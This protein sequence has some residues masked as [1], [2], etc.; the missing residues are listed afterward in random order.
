MPRKHRITQ[1]DVARCLG[2]DRTTVTKI[3]NRDSGYSASPETRERVYEVAR[4]LGYDF[5]AIRR[6]YRREYGRA[7]VSA[8]AELAVLLEDGSAYDTGTCTV[9]NLSAGGAL[10]GELKTHKMALPLANFTIRLGLRMLAGI[11]PITGQCEVVRLARASDTGQPELG[12]RFVDL[13]ERERKGIE[14][15]VERRLKQPEGV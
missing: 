9:L 10:L 15:W 13:P 14:Q 1:E 6:P 11:S 12:V 5:G 3:L 8:H 4:A 2:I 7:V